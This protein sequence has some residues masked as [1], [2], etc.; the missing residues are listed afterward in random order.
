[1]PVTA[2]PKWVHALQ[3]TVSG[4]VDDLFDLLSTAEAGDLR[5]VEPLAFHVLGFETL[6]RHP[7][8][9]SEK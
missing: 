6:C 3:Q 9:L 2:S 5:T 7:A 4:L 8:K 1:M